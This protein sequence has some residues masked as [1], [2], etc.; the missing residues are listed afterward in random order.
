MAAE[1]SYKDRIYKLGVKIAR[2]RLKANTI[3]RV[4]LLLLI[5]AL[6]TL[7]LAFEYSQDWYVEEFATYDW[8][9]DLGF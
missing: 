6:L 2:T 5:G 8:A 1:M 7:Y 9:R 4:R 3:S